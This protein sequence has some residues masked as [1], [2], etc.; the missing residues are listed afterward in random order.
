MFECNIYISWNQVVFYQLKIKKSLSLS[1]E[2][3]RN[4]FTELSFSK[5]KRRRPNNINIWVQTSKIVK[6]KLLF[7][8]VMESIEAIYNINNINL[9][10]K[11]S[12]T[13]SFAII[14]CSWNHS[15]YFMKV[16][17]KIL[18]FMFWRGQKLF[19]S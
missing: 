12:W 10:A 16:K 1:S 7:M 4:C 6:L 5:R 17:L 13:I 9:I 2:V 15:L 3:E 11:A 8:K 14:F 19:N 18:F